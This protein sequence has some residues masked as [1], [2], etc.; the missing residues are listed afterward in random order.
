MKQ[1]DSIQP[2]KTAVE[3]EAQHGD[4]IGHP[5][6]KK[7]D[8]SPRQSAQK[9]RLT[10]LQETTAGSGSNGLPSSLRTGIEALSGVDIGDVAV[11]RNS[12]KP[13]Q[14]NALAYAQ[15]SEI[16]L[17]PGQER[18]LPH[19]AWHIVQQR[20]G[21]VRPTMASADGT[22]VNDDRRL[23]S[24][25]D[26]MGSR[27]L[28]ASTKPV[29]QMPAASSATTPP[30]AGVAQRFLLVNA[31]SI[32]SGQIINAGERARD[33]PGLDQA[34]GRLGLAERFKVM[35]E[36]RAMALDNRQ[37]S[38]ASWEEAVPTKPRLVI[39]NTEAGVDVIRTTSDLLIWLVSHPIAAKDMPR[40]YAAPETLRAVMELLEEY[41]EVISPSQTW[42]AVRKVDEKTSSSFDKKKW[43]DGIWGKDNEPK[44]F[45]RKI[46]KEEYDE[47]VEKVF[48]R[49]GSHKFVGLHATSIENIG[50]LVKE[51]VSAARFG[52]GHGVGKG[53]GLYIIPTLG[54]LNKSLRESLFSWG[55]N[56]VGVFLPAAARLRS[57]GDGDNVE[58]LEA[59]R[60][61]NE[62]AYYS[63]GTAEAVIPPSLCDQV[64]LVCDPAH[65]SVAPAQY[66]AEVDDGSVDDFVETFV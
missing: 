44:R 61:D 9:S 7:I 60:E 38:Y 33:A 63:F 26:V 50:G 43:K 49:I 8:A 2:A 66:E 20:Q 1:S 65:I 21:R 5:M 22:P 56:Y 41:Q 28:D 15:G 37:H 14:M 25:A 18:H 19:E 3:Q 29:Q 45:R 30:A 12:A 10:Q 59:A 42:A 24:E 48:N 23:E 40:S 46:P 6:Q 31:K 16:H 64:I 36:L 13:A 52:S 47:A 55:S 32:S 4:A 17:G 34:L 35:A 62:I 11:H 57:A 53:K 51:G 54:N 27:A 39:G 58:T